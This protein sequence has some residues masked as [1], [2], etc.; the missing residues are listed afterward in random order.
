MGLYG[1]KSETAKAGEKS[2]EGWES[3]TKLQLTQELNISENNSVKKVSVYCDLCY[4]QLDFVEAVRFCQTCNRYLCK[5][6]YDCHKHSSI[7]TDKETCL[8]VEIIAPECL[9]EI[10][11]RG[12]EDE[13]N[14]WISGMALLST[15]DLVVVDGG[16]RAVKMIRVI[17]SEILSELKLPSEPFDSAVVTKYE[18]GVT[19]PEQQ[20]IQYLGI[21]NGLSKTRRMRVDGHCFGISHK[22]SLTVIT[23]LCP[24]KVEIISNDGKI[25]KRIETDFKGNELFSAPYYV[26]FCHERKHVYV[27]DHRKDAVIKLSIEGEIIATYRAGDLDRPEALVVRE[28]GSVVVA[29]RDTNCLHIISSRFNKIKILKGEE[30]KLERPWSLCYSAENKLL[31]VGNND[32][33]SINVYA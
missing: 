24:E 28:D 21:L 10:D 16:N 17:D 6:C 8:A 18:I 5:I 30:S 29:S 3:F 19:L 2:K 23:F 26:V 32:G 1:S 27:S 20:Q 25:L 22:N 4:P 15:G 7:R 9:K 14:C 11:P 33:K 31:Y 13:E 12:K